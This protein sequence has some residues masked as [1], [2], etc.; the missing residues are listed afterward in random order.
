[1]NNRIAAGV[2]FWTIAVTVAIA[3]ILPVRDAKTG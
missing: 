3:A 2:L 1:M